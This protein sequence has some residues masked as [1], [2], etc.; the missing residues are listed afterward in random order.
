[1]VEFMEFDVTAYPSAGEC[2]LD[3]WAAEL[4]EIAWPRENDIDI[5]EVEPREGGNGLNLVVSLPLVLDVEIPIDISFFVW[6]SI[7]KEAIPM[8]GRTV[9]V[10]QQINTEAIITFKI[11]EQRAEKAQIAFVNV[12]IDAREYHIQLG[13]IDLLG[14][15]DYY[16]SDE[17]PGG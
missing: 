4:Q 10:N 11:E 9:E 5:I 13:E 1:M 8:G 6:D 7:D 16:L 14:P 3:V 15:E 12:E 17:Q 2:E